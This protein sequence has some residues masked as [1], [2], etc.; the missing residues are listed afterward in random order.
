V[1]IRQT[2][3]LRLVPGARLS[4]SD[5]HDTLALLS[6]AAA[7][8]GRQ[9]FEHATIESLLRLIPADRAGYFEYGGGGEVEGIA[10]TFF[11]DE[12]ACCVDTLDWATSEVVQTTISSWPLRDNCD[13]SRPPLKLSDFLTR[14]QLHRNPWYCEVMRP[15]GIE[16]ELKLWLAAPAGMARGFF[17]VRGPRERDF[18]E[19]DRSLLELLQPH[20]LKIRE[21]WERRRRPSLL[22]DREAEVLGL[23][24]L[25][26]TNSEIAVRLVISRTTV[27]THLENI[28]GKLDVHTRT[29]AVAR[30]RELAAHV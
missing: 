3:Y 28:F 19:R 14:R 24:A 22:T 29:A 23:V 21:R 2:S 17:L 4:N 15:S 6:E 10:N 20:L 27:R 30:Q 25:G 7:V 5:H 8:D 26:L 13:V 12:P 18:E 11:V 9:P 16:H 1:S